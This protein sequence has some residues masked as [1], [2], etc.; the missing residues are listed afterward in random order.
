MIE[1][2]NLKKS[3]GDKTILH[4]VNLTLGTGKCNL[5]IGSSG[6]GKTVLMKCIVGLFAPDAGRI[7]YDGISLTEIPVAER[8]QLRQHEPL[9]Q[10]ITSP[11]R[12]R[13]CGAVYRR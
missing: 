2:Q 7:L 4:D 1:I 8:K 5:I 6:S 3:F 13:D 11:R 10:G 9:P 12:A